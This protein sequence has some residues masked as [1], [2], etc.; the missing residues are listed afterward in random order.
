MGNTLNA[1]VSLLLRKR[2][3]RQAGKIV[4]ELHI[5]GLFP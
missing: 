5:S 1:A 3:L 2:K 4:L